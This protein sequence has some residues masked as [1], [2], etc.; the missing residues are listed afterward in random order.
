MYRK[1][2][3]G[4]LRKIEEIYE[5]LRKIEEIY[6]DL[7]ETSIFIVEKFRSIFKEENRKLKFEIKTD[8]WVRRRKKFC[9]GRSG[10]Q[11]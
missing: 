7:L 2:Y 8:I 9:V 4:D 10:S 11:N 1:Y 6:G 3:C 5:K